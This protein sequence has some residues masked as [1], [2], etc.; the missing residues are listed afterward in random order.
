MFVYC[1]SGYVKLWTESSAC[2]LNILCFVNNAMC[3]IERHCFCS[4]QWVV[5]Y[6]EGA[7]NVPNILVCCKVSVFTR[8]SCSLITSVASTFNTS[9]VLQLL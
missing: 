6:D 3:H 7:T 8:L 4:V 1:S 9:H 2:L 5:D